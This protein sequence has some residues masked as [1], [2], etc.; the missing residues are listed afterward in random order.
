LWGEQFFPYGPEP[1]PDRTINR[2]TALGTDPELVANAIGMLKGKL[3]IKEQ[4]GRSLIFN[5]YRSKLMIYVPIENKSEMIVIPPYDDILQLDCDDAV[6]E[7]ERLKTFTKCIKNQSAATHI[8]NQLHVSR[9]EE[10]DVSDSDANKALKDSNYWHTE[11]RR[12]K[13]KLA[14]GAHDRDP[15]VSRWGERLCN[16]MFYRLLVR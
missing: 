14:D 1:H 13:R 5:L 6:A 16:H 12:E 15:H 10:E 8:A 2:E 7:C 3:K 11:A 4:S 9:I